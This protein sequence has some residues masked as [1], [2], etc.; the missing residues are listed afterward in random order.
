MAL[1]IESDLA[2]DA[3]IPDLDFSSQEFT[4]RVGTGFNEY[5]VR[6]NTDGETGELQSVDVIF[7]AMEPG[8]PD[9]R[10]GV[11]IT[12]SFLRKVGE[13]EYSESPPHLK[14][15]RAEDSF[16][17]IGKVRDVWFSEQLSKLM[18]MV[19]VPN[20]GA[21][22]HNE[23]VSRYTF[24][25]PTI[26]N[27]SVGFGDNYEAVRNDD[28]EPEL[29]DGK[30]REFS[31]VNFPGGYDSG[32]V[33]AAFAEEAVE[34]VEDMEFDDGSEEEPSEGDDPENSAADTFSITT[35]TVTY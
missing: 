8:P 29:V 25:P 11:R 12:E 26:R 24:E 22:T 2:F 1:E 7:E 21:P 6:E 16:A 28:G 23:A 30:L 14:D 27:G 4:D 3:T 19:R 13:K 32:G 33:A 18:L 10:N 31:T 20:T 35:E 17:D 5:G 34:A 9:R 15:H